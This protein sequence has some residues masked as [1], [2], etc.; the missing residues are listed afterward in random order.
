MATPNP[1][2]AASASARDILTAVQIATGTTL[3]GLRGVARPRHLVRARWAAMLLLTRAGY[4]TLVAGEMLG[5]DHSTVIHG[6]D[7]AAALADTDPQFRGLVSRIERLLAE[8][9]TA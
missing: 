5:R 4:S 3:A 2:V 7:K 9:A 6:R 8:E 1:T